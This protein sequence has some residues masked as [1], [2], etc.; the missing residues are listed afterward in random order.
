MK[1]E[2]LFDAIGMAEDTMIEN[3][4][5]IKKAKKSGNT[6]RF[7]Q[8]KS[9]YGA[10]AAVLIVALGVGILWKIKAPFGTRTAYAMAEAVYP[11]MNPMPSEADY[12][13]DDD[14]EAFN[15]AYDKW[16][17]DKEVQRSYYDA[18]IDLTSFYEK[19]MQEFLSGAGTD[20]RVYSPLNLYMALAMLA[21]TTD[22]ES[23]AQILSLLG[24]KD[25]EQL[26]KDVVS[27]W[28]S[29][30]SDDGAYTCVLANSLWLNEA[31]DV[32]K[33][34]INRLANNYYA[35][36]YS[37]NPAE[38]AYNQALRDWLNEQTGG[39]LKHMI[40]NISM[41]AETV[42]AL[43]STVYFKA[44]W[45]DEFWEN[46]TEP[47]T[48]YTFTGEITCDF[49]YHSDT[50]NYYWG[51]NFSAVKKDFETYRGGSSMTFILPDEGVSPEE[52][53]SDKEVTEFIFGNQAWKNAKHL[54]VNLS[55][56]KFDVESQIELAEGLQNLG[57]TDVFHPETADFSP[58]TK[59]N[60]TLTAATHGVRVMIDEEG[61][62]AA[63][64]TFMAEGGGSMPPEEEVDFV[65]NRPFLFVVTSETGAPLFIGIV[66]NPA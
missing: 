63:A 13:E 46:S 42:L 23:R 35:S 7:F 43:A 57:V 14:W 22:G 51:E 10:V 55:V 3:A 24:T 50:N 15:A 61:C 4:Q 40:D 18:S 62:T 17:E 44:G 16:S 6:K 27:L 37:G 54:I 5:E 38:E 33:D 34:T 48:F 53:L 59:E 29:N 65:C 64:F 9:F 20:N 2:E 56:P 1:P 19:S 49:M 25:I 58:V 39:L 8:R 41:D 66:N 36:S 26:R 60:I 52:L 47:D 45:N 28:N 11:E 21:E 31:V 30:Y 12:A 32:K